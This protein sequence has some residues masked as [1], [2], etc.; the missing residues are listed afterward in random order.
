MRRGTGGRIGMGIERIGKMWTEWTEMRMEGV[1]GRIRERKGRDEGVIPDRREEEPMRSL[2]GGDFAGWAAAAAVAAAA[3]DGLRQRRTVRKK[4][5]R[6]GNR[7]PGR[8]QIWYEDSEEAL[9]DER[10]RT[11]T[12]P[13][14]R[15]RRDCGSEGCDV[16]ARTGR[17]RCRFWH[18]LFCLICERAQPLAGEQRRRAMGNGR[19]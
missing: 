11:T 8:R 1:W 17:R 7:G 3:A 2:G 13:T 9:G 15:T 12:G 14:T 6:C 4:E 10:Q 16:F 5:E 19:R 18:A